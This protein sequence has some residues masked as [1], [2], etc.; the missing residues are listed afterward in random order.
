M[1]SVFVS[2][3][4]SYRQ[5]QAVLIAFIDRIYNPTQE[6]LSMQHTYIFYIAQV[7]K[8]ETSITEC[9]TAI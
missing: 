5:T 4:M 3:G 9:L 1:F 7:N 2:F 6:N 8:S